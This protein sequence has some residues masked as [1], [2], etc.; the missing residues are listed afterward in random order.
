MGTGGAGRFAP[1]PSG[2]LHL[3]NL[4]T[5]LLAWLFARASGRAALLRVEDLDTPRSSRDCA[6]RQIADLAALG[7]EWDGPPVY[8]S[9]R[10]AAY[11]AA[12]DSLAAADLVYPCFCTR[13]DILQAPRAPHSPPGAY[14]G[15]CRDLPADRVAELTA[16]LPLGRA[17]ALRL[18]SDGRAVTVN[19][20]LCGEHTGVVDDFVL[21]RGDGMVA[22][23]LAVIVDDLA[24][25]VDQ[26]LRAD[27]LLTSAPRQAYLAS[28][29]TGT[30][31]GA[32]PAQWIHVP[33]AL[34]PD[35]KRLA[36]RHGAVTLSDLSA[37]GITPPQAL[38]LIAASLGLAAPHEPVTPHQLIARLVPS[39]L[40]TTPWTPGFLGRGGLVE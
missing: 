28:L 27:D 1:S 32:W 22:Y 33:L 34:G 3:G 4:R 20:L 13:R 11:D 17:P 7:L 37:L 24:Q 23:N 38:T 18:R 29:L 15:T 31:D 36:K 26:V 35:G 9:D 25:G 19:D 2:D 21:L 40:P 12:I 16:A 5:A 6:D 10:R 8:Q 30:D 14:P 39:A